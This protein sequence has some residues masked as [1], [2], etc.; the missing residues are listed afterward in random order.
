MNDLSGMGC[1]SLLCLT[2][3]ITF[4]LGLLIGRNKLPFTVRI[5]RNKRAEYEVDDGTPEWK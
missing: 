1:V 4:T 2:P 3:I 5:E